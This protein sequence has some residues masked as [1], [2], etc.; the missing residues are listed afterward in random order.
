L[1]RAAPNLIRSSAV[2]SELV[3]NTPGEFARAIKSDLA[4]YAKLVKDAGIQPQ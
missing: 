3:G 2:S 4:K 1:V